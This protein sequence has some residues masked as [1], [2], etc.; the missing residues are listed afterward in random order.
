[1]NSQTHITLKNNRLKVD[2]HIP[3]SHYK[4]A[5]FDWC[6]MIEQVLLDNTYSFCTKE[7]LD[8]HR[9]S[10]GFGLCNEFGLEKAIGY[11]EID[12][13]AYFPKIGIGALQKDTGEEYKFFYPYK[14]LENKIDYIE[15]MQTIKF[16]MKQR[17]LNGYGYIYEKQITIKEN[18]VI[19][20]YY[21]NNIGTK[22]IYTTEYCHNFIALNGLLVDEKYEL[23]LSHEIAFEN[24][25]DILECKNSKIGWRDPVKQVFYLATNSCYDLNSWCLT[26]KE[27]G[28]SIKESVNQEVCRFALWGDTHVV[29]PEMFVAISLE[30]GETQRWH[31]TY[32]FNSLL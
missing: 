9:G 26:H 25:N 1:M 19:V 16:K 17:E 24:N 12:R 10:N 3:G 23:E 18:N 31:R 32:E 14:I 29:S 30:P 6:G 13:Q 21:L 20:A 2:I 15:E 27:T 4:G 7:S 8:P 28:V 5:R 22:P 11:E